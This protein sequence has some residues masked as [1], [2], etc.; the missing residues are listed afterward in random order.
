VSPTGSGLLDLLG[1]H[2][3]G[4]KAAR[5]YLAACRAGPVSA[6]ELARLSEVSRVEAYRIIKQLAADGLL[7]PTGTRPQR[8]A[9]LPPSELVDRWIR[10]AA[11]R[12]KRLE[13]DRAR[14]LEEWETGRT[15]ILDRDPRKF[16][17]LDGREAIRRFLR[18]RIGSAQ[19]RV[20]VSGSGTWLAGLI[21]AGVAR[22]LKEAAA[23]GVRVRVVT[24]VGLTNL[25][26]AKHF[27]AFADLRHSDAPVAN[28]TAVFDRDGALVFVSGEEGLGRSGEEQVA[29]WSSTPSFVQ[30]T[31][32]YFRRLWF[33]ATRAD[34]RFIELEDPSAAVLPVVA[35][36]ETVPFQRLK[37]IAKLGIRASGV[38]DFRLPLPELIETIAEQLGEE[39][40][41]GVD[42]TTPAAVGASLGRYYAEHSTGRLTVVRERP[43]TLQV[44]GCFACTPDS[45][46]IG[47]VMCP[48]LLRT[49][50]ETRLGQRWAVSKP[51]PTKHAT[52]GCTFVA[53]AA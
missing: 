19:R 8:F 14:V 47:R 3:V 5:L 1:E 41:K 23:R 30:L 38:R 40:A 2:G 15:E 4:D 52:R 11:D 50:L 20:L 28:R 36:K 45:T 16:A 9:A 12:V 44:T 31:R 43:L 39:I 22:A 7:A 21:D 18:K 24:E 29:L 33:P 53:T 10:R 42:G 37:E 6:R 49:V 13:G 25:A 51:D 32:E 34:S 27:A 46:E 17:V 35:G 48:Q 26:E